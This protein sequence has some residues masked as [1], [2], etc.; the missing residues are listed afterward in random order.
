MAS[1]T[2]HAATTTSTASSTSHTINIPAGVAA[3][4]VILI[5][6]AA[7]STLST[8]TGYAK[9][10]GSVSP[11]EVICK[12]ATGSEGTSVDVSTSGATPSESLTLL[13]RGVSVASLG[14]ASN[15]DSGIATGSSASPNPPSLA[16]STLSAGDG[17][18]WLAAAGF[19]A[20]S[21]SGTPSG[22]TS[23]G[24]S[25]SGSLSAGV[26]SKSSTATSEDPGAFSAGSD[27]T[28]RCFTIA[29]G[30]LPAAGGLFNLEAF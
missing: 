30:T 8:F 6:F 18:L 4:D 14:V 22:Y 5:V 25:A 24:I 23:Q 10:D 21:L 29:I 3:N 9:L 16:P 2:V 13:I 15:I 7:T 26:G 11:C 12:L 27:A 1:P 17:V 20:G 19:N 28:W